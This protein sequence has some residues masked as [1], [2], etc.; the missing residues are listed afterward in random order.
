MSTLKMNEKTVFDGVFVKFIM[1]SFFMIWFKLAGWEQTKSTHE[2]AGITIAA[3]HTSNWDLFY[4][5]GSAILMDVKIYFSLKDNWCRIPVIG[6]IMMWLGAIPIDRS[7]RGKGQVEQI[8]RFIK[9]HKFRRVY[10]LF[11]PEGT[12]SKV[13]KWKTG[14]YHIAEG[15][16]LPV[17]LAKVDYLNK[18]AK[19]FHSYHLTGDKVEDMSV[20]QE[21]YKYI[22]AKFSAK[23]FPSY[24]G[25]IPEISKSEATV[26]RAMYLFKGA[27]S[28]ME[29][30]A[31]TKLSKLKTAMLDVLIRKGMLEQTG[32]NK[33]EPTYCL[34]LA[35]KGCL[36]HLYPTLVSLDVD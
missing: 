14:F 3:P 10:F 31:K 19:V 27:V 16:G 35:G 21:A 5:L 36:L 6:K 26:M 11:T 24:V 20:I 34:T 25:P 29:I 22:L 2:G 28:K 8:T 4:A 15:C 18:C 23:Q 9:K 32:T 30:A 7:T 12:R 33:N 17:F 13:E 1:K